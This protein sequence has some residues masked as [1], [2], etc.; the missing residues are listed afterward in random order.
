M[1]IVGFGAGIDVRG[2]QD[3][4]YALERVARAVR[5]ASVFPQAPMATGTC[6]AD[7]T[8]VCSLMATDPSALD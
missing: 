4:M 6:V 3:Q 5:D 1:Q 8:L 2:T 7:V